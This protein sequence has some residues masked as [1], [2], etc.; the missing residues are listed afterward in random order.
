MRRSFQL[1]LTLL[2]LFVCVTAVAQTQNTVGRVVAFKKYPLKKAEIM[3]KGADEKVYSDSLGRFSI[4]CSKKDKLI[5]SANGFNTQ[6]VDPQK[7]RDSVLVNLIFKK[8]EENIKVATGYG[9]ID[10][11]KLTYAIKHLSNENSKYE[12]YA[13][14]F[15]MLKSKVPGVSVN[16]ESISIRGRN[17]YGVQPPLIVADGFI[18][19]FEVFRLMDPTTVKS[20]DILQDAA[21]SARYGSRGMN[22]VIVITSKNGNN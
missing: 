11:D 10:R 20:I 1:L 18:I 21:A 7:F 14:I 3:V 17:S 12:F 22:G 16:G 2:T 15:E 13:N 5:I 9:H 6:V 8:S 4:S 19:S